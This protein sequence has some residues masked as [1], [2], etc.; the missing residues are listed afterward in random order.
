M[1]GLTEARA[2]ELLPLSDGRRREVDR[3]P[4]GGRGE[5]SSAD[6]SRSPEEEASLTDEREKM[7]QALKR[8]VSELPPREQRIV[9]QRWLTDEPQ[10]LKELGTAFGVSKERVR[11][12]EGTSQDA[13]ARTASANRGR[14]DRRLGVC[15]GRKNRATGGEPQAASRRNAGKRGVGGLGL[16]ERS[17]Y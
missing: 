17:R 10:T 16:H 8:V 5:N 13:D 15:P 1:S 4:A 11:Q 6:R 12:L 7:Q 14:P 3:C 2:T 9:R